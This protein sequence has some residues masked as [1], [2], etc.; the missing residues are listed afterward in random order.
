MNRLTKLPSTSKKL[1][2]NSRQDHASIGT[3]GNNIYVLYKID[4]I[5]TVTSSTQPQ[6]KSNPSIT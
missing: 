5:H 2:L 1:I 3:T 6:S 4:S